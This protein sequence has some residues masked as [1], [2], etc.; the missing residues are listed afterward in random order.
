MHVLTREEMRAADAA[1]ASA[2]PGGEPSLM[3]SAGAA[4][5]EVCR[6]YAAPGSHVVCFAGRGN[7]GG[8][9]ALALASLASSHRCTLYLLH[10]R[11]ELSVSA[12]VA[13]ERAADRGVVV[14]LAPNDP[15][16]ALHGADLA[17][18]ALVG[19]GSR[20]PFSARMEH[21]I[22]ALNA[23]RGPVIAC[24]LP[25][26]IDPSTGE[27]ADTTLH[28]RATLA[29]GAMKYGLL[30]EPGRAHAGDLWV[31]EI[32]FPVRL[33]DDHQRTYQALEVLT[34]AHLVAERP[35]LV[36]K[37]AAGHVAI[38]AGSG[39]YPG[40]AVLCARAAARAGAGYVTLFV[41]KAAAATVRAHLVEVVVR[42]IP[43][44]VDELLGAL[45]NASAVA[46]GPGLGR[47]EE[48][49]MLVHALCAGLNQ[50]FVVDA[51]GVVALAGFADLVAGKRAVLTPHSGEFAR[52]TGLS[53][54]QVERDRLGAA[55]EFAKAHPR[56]PVL[57]LKG[58]PTLVTQDGMRPRLGWAGTS[59]LATAGSG[60]VLT[61]TI[62]TLLARGLAPSDA[63]AAGTFWHGLAGRVAER[64]RPG[65][66]MAG[67]ICEALPEAMG[68]ARA[69]TRDCKP[70][71]VRRVL[72]T[73][74]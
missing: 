19:T 40:A 31:C 63:A 8:D 57:L 28:A 27:C 20:L 36:D 73:L 21:V 41:P 10:E 37:Y 9:G 65:G 67:D 55:K 46:I 38:V 25:A 50:P 43:Q 17:I 69:A 3:G 59:A 30:V 58:S 44:D 47:T 53:R 15:S 13:V 6:A 62:A 14:S 29:L 68:L 18:E 26:G 52:L 49:R 66:V 54:E 61:G 7:N 2:I 34:F 12:R 24:D 33:L 32:G 42:E 74:P 64:H 56:G 23:F 60:D 16:A 11:H 51:D 39:E 45:T 48:T 4:L 1:G 72:P 22:H 71:C 70:G 5:A 35:Q